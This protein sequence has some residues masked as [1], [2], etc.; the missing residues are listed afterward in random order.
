MGF[1]LGDFVAE[2]SVGQ[3]DGCT[4]NDLLEIAAHYKINVS[5]Q[6][7]K[8][9]IKRQIHD[10]LAER[11]ILPPVEAVSDA[12]VRKMELQLEMR[13]LECREH[14]QQRDFEL[15]KLELE[16]DLRRRE[17]LQGVYSQRSNLVEAEFDVNKCIRLIPPFT[18]RDVDKYFV[19]FEHV[20]TTLGWPRNVWPL[21]LQCVFTGKAQEAYASLSPEDSLLYEK[22]KS[23]VERAYEL[24]PEAYRQK[25][26]RYRKA[27]HQSYVEFGREKTALFDRWCAAQN[28]K[29]FDQL[30]DIILMEEFKNCL[31][32]RIA[33]YINEQKTMNVSD[34]AVLADEYVLTHKEYSG[35]VGPGYQFGSNRQREGHVESANRQTADRVCYYCNK[36]GH[37]KA[38]CLSLKNKYRSGYANPKGAGLAAPVLVTVKPEVTTVGVEVLDS[39]LPFIREGYVSLVGS[40]Q[41]VCVKILRDTGAFDSFIRADVLPWSRESET[42]T[43]V[44]VRGMGLN[45]LFVPLRKVSLDCELFCG[46]AALA[47]RPALPMEGVSV[48]LGNGLAGARL[49]SDAAPLT[50]P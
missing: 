11:D 32:E 46:E 25:Y 16:A 48:I 7:K 47:V 29:T 27:D 19:L 40:D 35:H 34:A 22:V 5:K 50:V 37:L 41:K 12:E 14:E 33:T 15:R 45:V 13:R 36:R 3:L 31:S 4:K 49:W 42:G 10:I 23:A 1:D 24:V 28:V 20:A 9:I 17:S 6:D 8:K 21:L 44:P 30:R 39:Y 43:C 2:P 38:D 18:G 26:R